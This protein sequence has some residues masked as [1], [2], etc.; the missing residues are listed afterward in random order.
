MSFLHRSFALLLGAGLLAGASG[1]LSSDVTGT[2]TNT[3]A[4]QSGVRIIQVMGDAG[5]G[6]DLAFSGTKALSA[7]PFGVV[8]PDPTTS[9][10]TYLFASAAVPFSFSS[11]GAA[12]PFY[13]NSGSALIANAYFT[14]IA[15]GHVTPGAAPAGSVAILTDTAG[16][17]ATAVLIRVF[18]AIDYVS[19]G[20]GTRA[21][22]YIYPQGTPRPTIPTVTALSYGV[23]SSYVSVTPG[24]LQIDVYAAGAPTTSAPLFS[25]P[26]NAGA[27]VVRTLVLGDPAPSAATGAAGEVLILSDQG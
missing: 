22:V 19:P 21:D 8:V 12:T 5:S 20:S 1:C 17:S 3:T 15:F 25:A 24:L 11:A 14:M 16:H 13:T 26:L 18:N 2:G 9:G 27:S 23:A 10:Y 7:V 4:P 6:V